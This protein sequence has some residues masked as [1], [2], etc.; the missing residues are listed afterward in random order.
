MMQ[1]NV[2]GDGDAPLTPWFWVAVVITG[3]AAGLLG[4]VLMFILYSVQHLAF[5]SPL[6]GEGTLASIE[7]ASGW[8]RALP[9]LIAGVIGGPAWYLLR[10]FTPG[11]KTQVDEVLWT[12]E[13][14]LSLR[15]SVGTSIISEVVIGLGASLGRESAP[16]L[17]GAVAGS[18]VAGWSNLTAGQRRLLIACGGGAGFAAV[19]NVPLGGALF[20]AE[21]L[22]GSLNL[23]VVLPALVCA[24]VATATAWIYLPQQATYADV[25]SFHFD[26][27]I[28]VWALLL[29]P[30]VGVLAAGYVRLIGVISHYRV[31]GITALVAPLVAFAIL[32]VLALKYP[33]LYG[34]GRGM[35][36]EAFLGAG[37]IGLFLALSVLKPFVTVL[38]LGSGAA[39]GVFTPVMSTGAVLGAGLGLAWSHIWPGSPAGAYAVV[40][41]AAMIGA[42]TQA[43]LAAIVLVF[44]L[45]HS[46]FALMVPM[47]LATA[48][49]TAI[50]RWIDG[51]SIYS[52]RLGAT[53]TSA[54]RPD[55]PTP[56]AT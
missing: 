4:S 30:V 2:T 8:H 18:V 6:D 29:G 19:Y 45:T 7:A 14:R 41:A 56:V 47:I 3:V 12:G 46:G 40:G 37:T 5:G 38:C 16:K 43:P 11:R 27:R 28:L 1:P 33:Q 35:A 39:G 48:I 13:G 9:L 50:A 54:P 10:R 31:K 51:Y 53:S 44:E 17:M 23:P 52:A 24:G 15:R 26:V 22:I 25:P 32:A 21:V 55:D 36:H 34:N 20:T 49:A 42:A